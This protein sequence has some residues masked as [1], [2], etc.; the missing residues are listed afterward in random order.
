MGVVLWFCGF[1][2]RKSLLCNT[3]SDTK[4]WSS[5]DLFMEKWYAHR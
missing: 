5:L 3:L 1:L 4:L 2:S